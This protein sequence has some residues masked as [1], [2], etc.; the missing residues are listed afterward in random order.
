MRTVLVLLCTIGLVTGLLR[1]H[2][3]ARWKRLSA[4]NNNDN[5][6][7]DRGVGLPSAPER[8]TASLDARVKGVTKSVERVVS[9]PVTF[10]RGAAAVTQKVTDVLSGK[11]SPPPLPKEDLKPTKVPQ[12]T[13]LDI[14][15]DVKEGVYMTIDGYVRW[16]HVCR[17]KRPT[18]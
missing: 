9:A 12:P 2:P 14:F 10:F 1:P 5:N 11:P 13:A 16:L 4:T 6:N 7:N 17:T 8:F 18:T 3:A 15:E